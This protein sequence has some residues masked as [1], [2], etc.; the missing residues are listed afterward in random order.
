MWFS[1]ELQT[2][3]KKK[4][5]EGVRQEARLTC[6]CTMVTI[7]VFVFVTETVELLVATMVTG[8]N[9]LVWPAPTAHEHAELY[10]TVPEQ[11]DAY[12]GTLVGASV[13]AAQGA[14]HAS[15]IGTLLARSC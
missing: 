3:E 10:R 5:Y 6:V 1:G 15:A 11:A 2:K 12:F 9:V 8:D 4:Q 7:T 14:A 13:L